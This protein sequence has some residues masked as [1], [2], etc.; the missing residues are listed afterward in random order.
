MHTH[1]HTHITHTHTHTHMYIPPVVWGYDKKTVA[2]LMKMQRQSHNNNNA[3][4]DHQKL[5]DV[6][7]SEASPDEDSAEHPQMQSKL[8]EVG[9]VQGIELN[10]MLIQ[11]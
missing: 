8:T 7:A 6:C 1:T 4:H 9:Y 5:S 10:N 2:V 3:T 11:P